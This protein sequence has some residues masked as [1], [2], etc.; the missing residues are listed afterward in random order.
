MDNTTSKKVL[1][2]QN[3]KKPRNRTPLSCSV[4]RS[5]K[6]KCDKNR[7]HCNSCIKTGYKHICHYLE[8]EWSKNGY[9]QL[10]HEKELTELKEKVRLLEEQLSKYNGNLSSIVNIKLEDNNE[11][12]N[13]RHISSYNDHIR[14]LPN[15]NDN[16][17]RF[18]KFKDDD[19]LIAKRFESLHINPKNNSLSYLGSTHYLSILK[20]DPYLKI[21]WGHVFKI[22]EKLLEYH[23]YQRSYSLKQI[24]KKNNG[25]NYS[26][27]TNTDDKKLTCPVS[28][29]NKKLYEKCPVSHVEKSNEA[30]FKENFSTIGKCPI[31]HV[32]KNTS[33][34]QHSKDF[35]NN[36][37]KCPVEHPPQKKDIK[38]PELHNEN[39]ATKNIKQRTGRCPIDH[40]LLKK[41]RSLSPLT[42]NNDSET[43]N[44][45]AEDFATKL[46]NSLPSPS[47]INNLIN[48]FFKELYP[49]IPILN[50][51]L[52]KQETKRILQI[53]SFKESERKYSIVLKNAFEISHIG[54]LL[55]ILRL[56]FLNVTQDLNIDLK[57]GLSQD[58]IKQ[59]LEFNLPAESISK[60]GNENPVGLKSVD[61]VGGSPKQTIDPFLIHNAHDL[62]AGLN[63]LDDN[64]N[65]S[66]YSTSIISSNLMHIHFLIFYKWYLGICPENDTINT[67]TNVNS[68]DKKSELL[69]ARIIQLSFDC[70]LHRDPDNFSNLTTSLLKKISDNYDFSDPDILKE[71]KLITKEIQQTIQVFKNQWRKT[72][73]FIVDL[74][75]NQSLYNGTPRLLRKLGTF[76]DVK[77][78]YTSQFSSENLAQGSNNTYGDAYSNESSSSISKKTFL[79]TVESLLYNQQFDY[80]FNN[81]LGEI[82]I[83]KNCKLFYQL[84]LI[85]IAIS[86]LL[87]DSQIEVKCKKWK[88][89]LVIEI[90]MDLINDSG[91]GNTIELCI[92]KLLTNGLLDPLESYAL[93][94]NGMDLITPSMC[95]SQSQ[96]ERFLKDSG[97]N[98]PSL[99]SIFKNNET[100]QHKYADESF[101][102]AL[103]GKKLIIPQENITKCL[104]FKKHLQLQMMLYTLNYILFTSYEP[105]LQNGSDSDLLMD[106][107]TQYCQKTLKYSTELFKTSLLFFHNL[108]SNKIFKTQM[109]IVI[110]PY[111][112]DIMMVQD[113]NQAEQSLMK[114]FL[115]M[116]T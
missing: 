29:G 21:L 51:N 103:D 69:L 116:K 7:P 107:T 75:I 99:T 40:K 85:L 113:I 52:F 114:C 53:D 72:W 2:I 86:E 33:D 57:L 102:T 92:K 55:V 110:I 112:L 30:L 68:A 28:E 49:D 9:E 62:L 89:D 80:C 44:L 41:D 35:L 8:P 25:A 67:L 42:N 106:L 50:E 91:K 59:N 83:G 84:D 88:I 78:P 37:Q 90:L 1:K 43:L 109:K 97:Y 13:E 115:K 23:E 14:N 79:K 87:L 31:G 93:V 58:F 26:N 46:N 3:S 54:I 73:F 105:K 15:N 70:G 111:C 39:E 48:L 56:G 10:S 47:T 63:F 101:G 64:N 22:R 34:P 4:C 19:I 32:N 5:R 6:V 36:E 98:L 74:D 96:K 16:E 12:L 108:N 82:I 38:I 18:K 66:N 20:G 95:K 100:L 24:S 27:A 11:V 61:Y 76:S 45:C 94:A 71:P 104:F 17:E 77:L 60:L 65:G 81:D